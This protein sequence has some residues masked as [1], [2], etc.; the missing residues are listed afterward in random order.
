MKELNVASLLRKFWN[1]LTGRDD[2][3]DRVLIAAREFPIRVSY[4]D[5]EI[6][7]FEDQVE[8]ESTLEWFDRSD[9]EEG[10]VVTNA[11]G[12]CIYVRIDG[13]RVIQYTREVDDV[14]PPWETRVR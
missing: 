12:E 5:G 6:E 13:L 10:F 14:L 9:V 1:A 8:L 4:P 2:R 11:R 3:Y 7:I